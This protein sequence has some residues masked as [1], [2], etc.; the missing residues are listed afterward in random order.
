M[1]IWSWFDQ[2]IF[3]KGSSVSV[4]S[5]TFSCPEANSF[6]QDSLLLDLLWSKVQKWQD[7]P[8]S[9]P[10]ADQAF[11]RLS[12]IHRSTFPVA[13]FRHF[14]L[15]KPL[16]PSPYSKTSWCE[17]VNPQSMYC[18]SRMHV[19]SL[20]S[21]SCYYEPSETYCG[22]WRWAPAN[23][24]API[25]NQAACLCTWILHNIRSLLMS[26]CWPKTTPIAAPIKSKTTWAIV[27]AVLCILKL[28]AEKPLGSLN[29]MGH[30][31]LADLLMYCAMSRGQIH[32]DP[33]AS[34]G[35]K[36]W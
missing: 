4:P 35:R 28:N 11:S 7:I 27:F 34:N 29:D 26:F 1:R 24:C 25:T 36:A 5:V 12:S 18:M 9:W 21:W 14:S 23:C 3:W 32:Y 2:A 33:S 19:L 17:N 22:I 6:S 10:V 13:C 16:K 20:P 8:A 30:S 31:T 15:C